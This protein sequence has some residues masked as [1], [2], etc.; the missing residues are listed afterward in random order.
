VVAQTKGSEST[1]PGL[2]NIL[3]VLAD[4]LGFG[5]VACNHP[6]SKIA[7]PA[8]DRLAR[9]G[10]R[11]TDAHSPSAVCTPTRYA[12]LTGQY[13]WRTRLKNGVLDGF[14]PPLIAPEQQTL[15]KLL[16]QAGYA[17]HCLGKW[18]LGMQWQRLD[19]S[20]ETADRGASGFRDGSDL[21]FNKRLTG[22]PLGVGFEHFFGISA[23]LDMPPY[24]W[25]EDERCQP[26]P[27]SQTADHRGEMFLSQTAGKAHSAFQIDEVLPTLKRRTIETMD[28]HFQ[29]HSNQ[30]LFLY[31]PLTS[32]HLPVAPSPAFR[33]KSQAGTY[34]DFVMETDDFVQGIIDTLQRCGELS[35]TLLIVTSDNGGLWH[36]WEAR[37]PEDVRAY[38]PTDR[39]RYTA[40]FGHH[41][42]AWLRGTK[43]D[44]YEGGHRVPFILHWPDQIDRPRVEET[45]VEL[46]DLLATLADIVGIELPASILHDSYSF[47]SLLGISSSSGQPRSLL[48]HHSISGVFSLRRG[49]WKYIESRGSGGFSSPKVVRPEV[50]TPTGQ[51]YH[52]L[53]DPREARNVFDDYPAEVRDLQKQLEAVRNSIS[54][55]HLQDETP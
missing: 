53:D 5:D 13:C 25:I 44:I 23:S 54:L 52:L 22:G 47:A 9:H 27:D 4:D 36:T 32:P 34:G 6:D 41:S 3:I 1:K 16:Q 48:V 38:R 26:P 14:S 11:F 51:L 37:E 24:C 46:T 19:G 42:N 30:P 40:G 12:L 50:G 28:Q 31:L 17:T 15:P 10:L 55:H 8:I 18:H 2:P 7:T 45:P 35:N 33:G 29:A 20:L 49:P 39:G 43:A 21:D